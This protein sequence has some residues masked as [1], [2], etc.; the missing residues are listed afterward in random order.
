MKNLIRVVRCNVLLNK[1]IINKYSA[2]I[3]NRRYIANTLN[4]EFV[5]CPIVYSTSL[6]G[7]L[8]NTFKLN[9]AVPYT[10]DLT[11]GN[12][13][14]SLLYNENFEFGNGLSFKDGYSYSNDF[15][16]GN[17]LSNTSLG[18]EEITTTSFIYGNNESNTSLGAEEVTTT[19]FTYGNNANNAGST[20]TTTTTFIYT[21]GTTSTTTS[22]TST[23]A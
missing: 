2:V 3:S 16:F 22:T 21:N 11:Y 14:P 23:T 6:I 8:P 17:G 13:T 18:T 19:T 1:M 9:Q 4:V 7:V 10:I 12:Y 5:K 15:I 20:S